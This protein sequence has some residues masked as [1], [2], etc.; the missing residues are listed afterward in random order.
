MSLWKALQRQLG[1]IEE[2]ERLQ[3]LYTQPYQRRK[4]IFGQLSTEDLFF[5][6]EAFARQIV[7]SI[8][9]QRF[10]YRPLKKH[11]VC[12]ATKSRCIYPH[13]I[14]DHLVQRLIYRYLM[15]QIN[16]LLS[17]HLFSYRPGHSDKQ[18]RQLL[19]SY[20]QQH[21]HEKKVDLYVAQTDLSNYTDTIP[22][23]SHQPLWEMLTPY[24]E[25]DYTWK[26]VTTA[27]RA[28]YLENDLL[29]CRLVGVPMGS[30][31]TPLVANLYLNQLDHHFDNEQGLL[32]L[33]FGD[34]I[35][36]ASTNSEHTIAAMTHIKNQCESLGLIIN[37]QKTHYTY[38]TRAGRQ[39]DDSRFTG[40]SKINYLGHSIYANAE[41]FLKTQKEK[42]L[43]ADIRKK[44]HISGA[45]LSHLSI[46]ERGIALCQ[47]LNHTFLNQATVDTNEYQ[48]KLTAINH[49]SLLQRLDYLIALE[50]AKY[51][52]HI[53]SVK[54]FRK[55][56]YQK[57]RSQFGLIS[58]CQFKNKEAKRYGKY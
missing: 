11:T 40:Q 35:L 50:V 53:K 32:Y 4:I 34:D 22:L 54:A 13:F 43:I 36:V 23:Q 45:L 16:P 12:T 27:I 51:L 14:T 41:I 31:L 3:S 46:E 33:R 55:V 17:P 28:N 48:E 8:H 20:I 2:I 25:D 52:T 42:Q 37:P 26:L 39:A 44:I 15:Q 24:K 38:L 21:T 10:E 29:L 9:N 19:A 30:P 47:M 7:T 49:R 56:P 1:Y 6:K 58:L 57:I 5:H 18:A